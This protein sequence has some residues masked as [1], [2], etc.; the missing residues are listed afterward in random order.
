MS[1]IDYPITGYF[2]LAQHKFAG[3]KDNTHGT[4]KTPHIFCVLARGAKGS[5]D[6][7]EKKEKDKYRQTTED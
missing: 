4:A 2:L 6:P 3:G 5:E 7:W 1:N